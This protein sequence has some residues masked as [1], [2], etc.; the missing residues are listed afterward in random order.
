[1]VSQRDIKRNV[2]L[3]KKRNIRLKNNFFSKTVLEVFGLVTNDK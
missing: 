3:G 1:M 2:R